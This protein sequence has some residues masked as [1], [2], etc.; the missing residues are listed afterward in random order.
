ML[1]LAGCAAAAP[2][3][4]PAWSEPGTRIEGSV[5][6]TEGAA[7]NCWAV[8]YTEDGSTVQSPLHVPAGYTTAD[9]SM[10]NPDTPGEDIPGPALMDAAGQPVGFANSN[11]IIAGVYVPLDDPAVAGERERCGWASPPLVA[12]DPYGITVDPDGLPTVVR[13]CADDGDGMKAPGD[14]GWLQ[15]CRVV[16]TE[17]PI[18]LQQ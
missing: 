14:P 16:A 4:T 10:A 1:L 9:I 17:S 5:L 15:D 6:L 11:V 18:P 7:D 2:A 13:I 12:D 8:S 3:A